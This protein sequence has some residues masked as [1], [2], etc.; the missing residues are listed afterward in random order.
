MEYNFKA[1]EFEG[2]LDLLLHLIKKEDMNIFDINI[3]DITDQYLKYIENLES[4][5]L[6]IDSEYLVIA[7]ELIRLKSCELLPHEEVDEEEDTKEDFINRLVEYQKYKDVCEKFRTYEKNR[8]DLYT[9]N[10]SLLEEFRDDNVKIS[11]DITLDDL[12]K[13]YMKFKERKEYEKPLNTVVTT[14]EYSVHK[15]AEEVMSKIRKVH[16][17][18]FDELFDTYNRSYVVVTF[19]AIL[20]LAKDGE[21]SISQGSGEDSIFLSSVRS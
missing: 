3:S 9:R 6:N 19:L 14:K 11:D 2:P 18:R 7:S 10:V 15:R 13:A 12:L 20:N 17:I 16:N 1:C 5:N 4:L 8:H 21:I